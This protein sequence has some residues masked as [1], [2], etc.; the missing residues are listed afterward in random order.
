MTQFIL[1]L[2]ALF[3]E[4]TGL[5]AEAKLPGWMIRIMQISLPFHPG[6]RCSTVFIVLF[7][8]VT[9]L[10]KAKSCKNPA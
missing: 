2:N 7:N 1:E 4:L 3:W 5:I 10:E 6:V 9:W 8:Y